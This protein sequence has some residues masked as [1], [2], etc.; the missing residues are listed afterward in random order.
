L[1]A[2]DIKNTQALGRLIRDRRKALGLTQQELVNVAPFGLTFYSDL[3]NGKGTA[4]LGKTL[5]AIRLLGLR[6]GISSPDDP[7]ADR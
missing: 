5:A 4:Q 2:V 3:E 6:L 1:A 7:K